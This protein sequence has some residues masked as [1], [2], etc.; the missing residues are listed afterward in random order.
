MVID[1][2]AVKFVPEFAGKINFYVTAADKLL[3]RDDNP[4]VG[5]I[6]C[7]AYDKTIV[8]WSLK[9]IDKPLGV[10]AYQLREVVERT[11]NELEL[12]KKNELR[13]EGVK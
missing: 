2:K 4:S 11:V 5:L 8:E 12:Q 9:D 3:K 10:A 1:L 7:K 13:N 6:I